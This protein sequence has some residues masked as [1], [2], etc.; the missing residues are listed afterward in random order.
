MPVT[1]SIQEWLRP[2]MGSVDARTWEV[3][4]KA[5][6]T[7][8]L[9]LALVC[10]RRGDCESL[11]LLCEQLAQQ[12]HGNFLSEGQGV[13]VN[14]PRPFLEGVPLAAWD[15]PQRQSET[16]TVSSMVRNDV[17]LEDLIGM[18]LSRPRLNGVPVQPRNEADDWSNRQAGH[19]TPH[20]ARLDP[21]ELV[22]VDAAMALFQPIP[23]TQHRPEGIVR[24]FGALTGQV[25][26]PEIVERF[27]NAGF[28]VDRLTGPNATLTC[29]SVLDKRR[30]SAAVQSICL[31]N[32]ALTLALLNLPMAPEVKVKLRTELFEAMVTKPA[33]NSEAG[34][35]V[36]ALFDSLQSAVG[37]DG[38]PRDERFTAAVAVCDQV[39]TCQ[40]PPNTITRALRLVAEHLDHV[41]NHRDVKK[42]WSETVVHA[43]LRPVTEL[44]DF[45]IQ[46]GFSDVFDRHPDTARNLVRGALRSSCWPLLQAMAPALS[47]IMSPSFWGEDGFGGWSQL[48]HQCEWRGNSAGRWKHTLA[49]LAA[50]GQDPTVRL[51]MDEDEDEAFAS[52]EV[53]G[54]TVKHTTLMHLVAWQSQDNG[55]IE[56][57]FSLLEMGADPKAHDHVVNTPVR[58]M[59]NKEHAGAWAQMCRS[60][61]AKLAAEG[62]LLEMGMDEPSIGDFLTDFK[63]RPRCGP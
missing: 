55:T 23:G 5:S 31:G 16:M 53:I 48:A 50:A 45:D 60:H 49:V 37:E 58:Y 12:P 22:L 19:V 56:R 63:E 44:A 38:L 25:G 27:L 33:T 7:A 52:G 18:C 21:V 61:E 14:S 20:K 42:S 11:A 35:N 29:G 54:L 24:L 4:S 1:L 51:F 30:M 6:E 40:Y 34:R 8:M 59:S 41:A 62:A 3:V 43:L 10:A 9:D 2:P 36:S 47:R 13:D 28:S 17:R 46:E 26:A 15:N 57:M 39:S 32:P